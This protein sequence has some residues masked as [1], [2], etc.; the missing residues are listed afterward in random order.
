MQCLAQPPVTPAPGSK[1]MGTVYPLRIQNHVN[2]GPVSVWD[3]KESLR[4]TSILAVTTLSASIERSAWHKYS[5]KDLLV[6]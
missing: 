3:V 4:M 2:V 6:Q 1:H 5:E